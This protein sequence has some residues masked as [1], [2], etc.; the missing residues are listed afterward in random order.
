MKSNN[1]SRASVILTGY[2]AWV[3]MILFQGFSVKS[4]PLIFVFTLL[5]F[6]IDTQIFSVV[7]CCS[8]V[9]LIAPAFLPWVILIAGL[10]SSVAGDT[11]K[12]RIMGFLTVT[13]ILWFFPI[14]AS[15]PLVLVASLAALF[16]NKYLRYSLVPA[17]FIIS[18]LLIGLP[19]P[20][21][22]QPVIAGSTITDGILSYSIPQVNTSRREVLLAAP[23]EGLWAVWIAIEA[24]GVRDSIPMAAIRLGDDM[25]IL[26]AG[27][28]TLS[29]TMIPGDTLAVTLM[30]DFRRFNHSVIH[31]TAGG[32]RL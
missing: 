10:L 28:D 11:K 16:N 24:G 15:I 25:L 1:V 23:H 14:S 9:G 8:L 13:S 6:V 7:F 20:V 2:N 22:V 26:P 5:G 30:R 17:G 18:V 12:I 27:V 19:G 32:E 31:A 29:F 3:L 21:D 4:I